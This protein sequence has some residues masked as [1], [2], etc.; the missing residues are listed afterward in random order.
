MSDRA[1]TLQERIDSAIDR[2]P[3]LA[4]R[5]FTIQAS[6][7]RIVLQGVVNS[8]YQKQ[9]AQETAWSVEGVDAVEN[10]LQVSW[11]VP[12]RAK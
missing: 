11:L 9:L 7:G 4:G 12:R 10:Q 8:Y 6:R 1:S 3:H 5:H 2:N